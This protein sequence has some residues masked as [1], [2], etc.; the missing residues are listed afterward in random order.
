MNTTPGFTPVPTQD[1]VAFCQQ[2][3]LP[4]QRAPML[5]DPDGFAH[6]NVVYNAL[7]DVHGR[8]ESSAELLGRISQDLT[9]TE[10]VRHEKAAKVANQLAATA[11]ATQRTLET[12]AK[13][14]MAACETVMGSRFV[15]DPVRTPIYMRCLDWVARE[16]QNG[17]GGYTNIREAVTEDPDF[18]LT[19]YNHSWRLMGLPEDVVLGFKEKVVAKFAPEAL[20][21]IE[22][23]TTLDRLAKRYPGFIAKVHSSFYSPLE[24]A[25]LRT[26]VEV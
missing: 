2:I 17:D 4:T 9:V 19:M 21:H 16:A 3:R 10:P 25:K 15:P 7:K 14:H 24:L 22:S 13:E 5:G 11:E 23:S 26:R 18:A 6:D 1:A 12:R 8:A 20:E